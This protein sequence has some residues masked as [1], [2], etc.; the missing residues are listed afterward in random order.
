MRRRKW[1]VSRFPKFVNLES[2]LGMRIASRATKKESM[3]VL[4]AQV[5]D[6]PSGQELLRTFHKRNA[7]R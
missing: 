7:A 1:T 6:V 2:L 3:E 5:F 4:L